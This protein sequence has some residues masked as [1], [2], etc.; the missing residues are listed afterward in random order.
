[1]AANNRRF[2]FMDAPSFNPP[3]GDGWKIR[4]TGRRSRGYFYG[5]AA[6]TDSGECPFAGKRLIAAR[7]QVSS[8]V[9]PPANQRVQHHETHRGA[10]RRPGPAGQR[11]QEG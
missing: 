4:P 5:S 7:I 3:A 9:N 8:T 1:M 10:V 2:R 11:L 6:G